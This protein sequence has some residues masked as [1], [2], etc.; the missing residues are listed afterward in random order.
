MKTTNSLAWTFDNSPL[1]DPHGYGE[2]AVKFISALRHAKSSLPK[3][4]LQLDP[5]QERIVRRIYGDTLPTRSHRVPELTSHE[6]IKLNIQ[7]S[8]RPI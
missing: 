1:P 8:L 5:W 4:Q 3:K 2:R 6:D 7:V